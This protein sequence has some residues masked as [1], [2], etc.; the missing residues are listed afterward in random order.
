MNCLFVF[1]GFNGRIS[2]H[3]VDLTVQQ[4]LPLICTGRY[5]FFLGYC[6]H[7]L[8]S[9]LVLSELFL[10]RRDNSTSFSKVDIH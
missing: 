10:D 8:E 1:G 5:S 9:S 2:L 4:V 6:F 7:E 3:T